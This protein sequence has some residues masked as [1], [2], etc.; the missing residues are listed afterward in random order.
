MRASVFAAH[1]D[2]S[3]IEKEISW[4]ER[5]EIPGIMGL[6]IMD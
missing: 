5:M 4:P 1:H 2:A 3:S 6:T